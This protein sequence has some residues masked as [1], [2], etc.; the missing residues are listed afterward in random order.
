LLT[1]TPT[2]NVFHRDHDVWTLVDDAVEVRTPD[3]KGLRDLHTLLARPGVE[4][5]ATGLAT[6]AFVP[7]DST[8]V[9]DAQA[10]TEYR[11]R[12]HDLDSEL[13]RAALRGD[14]VRAATLE[15]ERQALLDELRRASDLGGRDRA[16]N[17]ERERLRKRVTARIRD[18]LRRLDDRRP[19]RACQRYRFER[20]TRARSGGG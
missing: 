15:Q 10:R 20:S 14:A 11:R 3:A 6:D 4:V 12:L 19:R 8:P 9:L 7:A 13:D 17:A 5:P 18:A 16:I 2:R 1:P